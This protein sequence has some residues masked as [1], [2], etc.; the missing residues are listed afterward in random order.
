MRNIIDKVN[1]SY[2]NFIREEEESL[3]K[4][5]TVAITLFTTISS[6]LVFLGFQIEIEGRL[7]KFFLVLSLLFSIL[8]VLASISIT[9][10]YHIVCKERSE[11]FRKKVVK[12]IKKEDIEFNELLY[13]FVEASKFSSW[14]IFKFPYIIYI[15]IILQLISVSLLA[16]SR[17]Y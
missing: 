5:S 1:K 2:N 10:F 13:S 14:V 3:L 9:F 15:L 16:F 17:I 12:C 4:F 8:I 11:D 7:Q 6:A